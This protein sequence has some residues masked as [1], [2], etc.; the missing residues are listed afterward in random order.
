MVVFVV[1]W[2]FCCFMVVLWFL[3][4][5]LL[6]HVLGLLGCFLGRFVHGAVGMFFGVSFGVEGVFS[7]G[8]GDAGFAAI[9]FVERSTRLFEKVSP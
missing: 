2:L 1:L 5:G 6:L 4:K 7:L 9:D 8:L 3:F